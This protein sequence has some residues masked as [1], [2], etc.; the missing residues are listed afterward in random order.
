MFLT[1]GPLGEIRHTRPFL[2]TWAARITAMEARKQ[3][4]KGTEDDQDNPEGHAMSNSVQNLTAAGR[5]M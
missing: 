4:G 5:D 1:D 3:I 2:S